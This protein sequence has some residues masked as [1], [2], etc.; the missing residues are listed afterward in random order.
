MTSTNE[1][2]K[3]I[4]SVTE[5]VTKINDEYKSYDDAKLK[6]SKEFL[7]LAFKE[8]LDGLTI[9]NQED[10]I[11]LKDPLEQIAKVMDLVQLE[12]GTRAENMYTLLT[13]EEKFEKLKDKIKKSDEALPHIINATC[14][15]WELSNPLEDMDKA[16]VTLW[17]AQIETLQEI[18]K[19]KERLSL[20]GLV[21]PPKEEKTLKI[22][23]ED[24][25]RIKDNINS[26]FRYVNK[27]SEKFNQS[28]LLEVVKIHLNL[29]TELEKYEVIPT[30]EPKEDDIFK[31][32]FDKYYMDIKY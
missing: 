20:L 31:Y 15:T 30:P 28:H 23:E 14:S 16:I 19:E 5:R 3:T 11:I 27:V 21:I 2:Q 6:K 25:E 29:L 17:E 9:L 12:I 4:N 26:S 10:R 13:D 1:Y 24:K 18:G 8:M 7:Y 22:R 32:K